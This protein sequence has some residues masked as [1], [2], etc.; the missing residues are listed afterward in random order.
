MQNYPVKNI[1]RIYK[2]HIP[3]MTYKNKLSQK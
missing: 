2:S 1:I 3:E